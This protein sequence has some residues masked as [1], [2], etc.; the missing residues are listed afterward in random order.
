MNTNEINYLL[1]EIKCFRGTFPRDM[2]PKKPLNKPCA[3]IMNSDKASEPGQHWIALFL[4]KDNTAE[5]FDSF[6][7]SPMH[8]DVIKFFSIN[9]VKKILYNHKHLQS[10]SMSTWSILY[11]IC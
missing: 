10:V 3:L 6:G 4:N 2:L 1:S 7:I 8:E 11:F 5:Y 9:N